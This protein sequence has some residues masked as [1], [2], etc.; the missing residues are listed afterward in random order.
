MFGSSVLWCVKE[1][2]DIADRASEGGPIFCL[3]DLEAIRNAIDGRHIIVL[4]LE[5]GSRANPATMRAVYRFVPSIRHR[6]LSTGEAYSS[7]PGGDGQ[8]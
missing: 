7:E 3:D 4:A 2:G 6:H 8:F 5:K 1:C